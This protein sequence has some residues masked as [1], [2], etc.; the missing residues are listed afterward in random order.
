MPLNIETLPSDLESS[1]ALIQKQS[2]EIAH[3]KQE[4]TLLKRMIFGQKSE[5]FVPSSQSEEQTVLEGLFES[6]APEPGF[7]ED[8]ET[9]TYERRKKKKGH[10]RNAIPDDLYCEEIVLEPSDKE[11]KCACCGKEKKCMSIS[12]LTMYC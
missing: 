4:L 8:K 1:H 11:K 9:I 10:G 7:A 6:D 3:L 2:G 5:K 12:S